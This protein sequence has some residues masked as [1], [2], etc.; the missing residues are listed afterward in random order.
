MGFIKNFFARSLDNIVPKLVVM[1]L[2]SPYL[3]SELKGTKNER[4]TITD[5][6]G[7]K[8]QRVAMGQALA[9]DP[10]NLFVAGF[11][12]SPSMNYIPCIITGQDGR[13]EYETH[14]GHVQRI[15]FRSPD[16]DTDHRLRGI[17]PP[18]PAGERP[19]DALPALMHLGSQS[20]V[21]DLVHRLHGLPAQRRR[22]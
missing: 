13:R 5:G 3:Y 7:G 12:G 22:I 1:A 17:R 10:A 20:P 6:R 21:V 19:K 15:V 2:I 4:L 8:R 14:G 16:R 11:I 9:R 18:R